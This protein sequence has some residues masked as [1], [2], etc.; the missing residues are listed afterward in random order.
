M[1][2]RY[3]MVAFLVNDS[4]RSLSLNCWGKRKDLKIGCHWL[5]R[6]LSWAERGNLRRRNETYFWTVAK[7]ENLAVWIVVG[8]KRFTWLLDQPIT[9]EKFKEIWYSR[10]QTG[11]DLCFSFGTSPDYL[12]PDFGFVAVMSSSR[13]TVSLPVCFSPQP[14]KWRSRH[15]G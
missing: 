7:A 11:A 3:L 1:K 2:N 14:S 12:W 6:R 10:N 5:Y 8:L 15:I 4:K 9:N 13:A